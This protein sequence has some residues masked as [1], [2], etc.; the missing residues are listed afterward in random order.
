[1]AAL[2]LAQAMFEKRKGHGGKIFAKSSCFPH[3]GS[4]RCTATCISTDARHHPKKQ[5]DLMSS[6]RELETGVGGQ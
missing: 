4:P 2:I 3:K 1:M 5:A 6:L